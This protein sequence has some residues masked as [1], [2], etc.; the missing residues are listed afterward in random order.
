MADVAQ[1]QACPKCGTLTT[2]SGGYND[3]QLYGICP[4]CR[5]NVSMV[6]HRVEMR[7]VNGHPVA[8]PTW[9][10]VQDA[11]ATPQAAPEDTAPNAQNEIDAGMASD[12]EIPTSQV[13][14]E[15]Y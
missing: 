9:V 14:L 10:T 1:A 4:Y 13:P 3:G 2:C 6:H 12:A 11:P 7:N 8:Q 5:A 15:G